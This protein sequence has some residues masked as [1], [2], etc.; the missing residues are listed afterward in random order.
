[1]ILTIFGQMENTELKY[2]DDYLA[3]L[4]NSAD[5]TMTGNQL[6][7]EL[8][9]YEHQKFYYQFCDGVSKKI[10]TINLNIHSD[11][12]LNF[13]SDYLQQKGYVTIDNKNKIVKLTMDG[14]IHLSQ[15]GFVSKLEYEKAVKGREKFSFFL[16]L[17]SIFLAVVAVLISI[18]S[19]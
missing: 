16:S 5:Y 4:R 12:F 8:S 1:V 17:F 7:K 13:S 15:G 6:Y 14:L 9:S 3:Y 18:Y 2:L 19:K 11:I 10:T